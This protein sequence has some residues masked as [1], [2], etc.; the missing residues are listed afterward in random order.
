[1]YVSVI[2]IK[3]TFRENSMGKYE[4]LTHYL[5]SQS[6]EIWDARFSEVERILGFPLP[7]SAH[8]YPAWWANQEPGHSQTRGWRD[9]G[10]ET[11][12]VDLASK[13]VRFRRRR[14]TGRAENAVKSSGA[15]AGLWDRAR[16]LTGIEDR[17]ALIELALRE[18]IQSELVRQVAELGGSDPHATAAPRRRFA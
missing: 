15:D 9:A 10:W 2:Y 12:Q 11:S 16:R 7:R 18:L 1:M 13:K 5:E 4:P 6:E 8:E 3:S 14:G 17:D